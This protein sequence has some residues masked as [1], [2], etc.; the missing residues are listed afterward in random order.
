MSSESV[1][2]N[3]R[4]ERER[5]LHRFV[6]APES[7]GG[8]AGAER[9]TQDS[10]ILP[11]VWFTYFDDPGKP[12]KL[13][14]NPYMGRSAGLVAKE[15]RDVTAKEPGQRVRVAHLP[16]IVAA[17]LTF[18][19]MMRITLPST[20]WWESRVRA[21]MTALASDA[22]Q[23]AP[24]LPDMLR[25]KAN[26][27]ARWM[28]DGPDRDESCLEDFDI[29]RKRHEFLSLIWV[30]SQIIGPETPKHI[31]KRMPSFGEDL[32]EVDPK[33]QGK[34]SEEEVE[35]ARW[36]KAY[37]RAKAS[38]LAFCRIYTDW[39]NPPTN[40]VI[41]SI[42]ADRKAKLSGASRSSLSIK[43]DAGQ[44]LFDI[45]CSRINWAIIDSGIDIS[46]PAFRDWGSAATA[47]RDRLRES[48]EAAAALTDP[49]TLA[50]MIVEKD[51]E[52][53]AEAERFVAQ[54]IAESLY[55]AQPLRLYSDDDTRETV[56]RREA[57]KARQPTRII[58]R[59][60]FTG[61]DLLLDLPTA[62][63]MY[64]RTIGLL[65]AMKAAGE[66]DAEELNEERFWEMLN[67][68]A[69]MKAGHSDV[70]DK[71]EFGGW[72][73]FYDH[74]TDPPF[75]AR[76]MRRIVEA[77]C[78]R[79][80]RVERDRIVEEMFP[81]IEGQEADEAAPRDYTGAQENYAE[82]RNRAAW[83]LFKRGVDGAGKQ[84]MALCDRIDLGLENDWSMLETFLNDKTP[85][86]PRSP[87]GTQ[88]AGVL[89]ADWRKDLETPKL[90]GVC[91]DIRL[92]DM[93]ISEGATAH[94]FEA[95]AA[96][97]FILHLNAR[98]SKTIHGTN[99]SLSV[100]HKQRNYGCGKTRICNVAEQ[101]VA[102]G[103]VVVAAAGNAG[104]ISYQ[105]EGG[106]QFSG[107]QDGS[108]TDPGNAE[109]VITVGSTHASR[110]HQYGVSYFSSRGP[111]GDGR[112]K[113]DIVAPGEKLVAPGFN[114]SVS[115]VD[116]TSFAAPHVSGA[117]ALL[118]A[119]HTEMIGEPE[120]L[121]HVLLDT[122]TD[123]GR[124]PNF[125]GA[126]MLDTLRALQSL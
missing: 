100:E 115:V 96:M 84:I 117:A 95:I 13:L 107:Y 51:I 43:A 15:L 41:W 82:Y 72:I 18:R 4:N 89:A 97:Q 20:V 16:G 21:M 3:E 91:P 60:D 6:F 112:R 11:D 67:T 106:A 54:T 29:D 30:A 9:F 68:W 47:E 26:R 37:D 122:A 36:K 104:T 35:E 25:H 38:I 71:T 108:I 61:L 10:P 94:E 78:F 93:R 42:A 86:R 19:Q 8:M 14:I 124:D 125:Q 74:D 7:T 69:R 58:E 62:R 92:Y 105:T 55:I 121:K 123:L 114:R 27:V 73:D 57:N 85:E 49:T 103:V 48:A 45:S 83:E 46:S 64:Q 77:T 31:Q 2:P 119:R 59:Y 75:I 109:T 99:V 33:A 40:G 1:S 44:R 53:P 111:T 65:A 39:N 90:Q 113:P 22:D 52:D 28:V 66:G 126:G 81:F 101:L 102:S 32:E 23:G 70:P 24:L 98:A 88:V 110:P 87:H 79:I 120:R 80:G 116:G 76:M 12:Q 63:S 50:E 118:M 34:L 5:W 17:T 56:L